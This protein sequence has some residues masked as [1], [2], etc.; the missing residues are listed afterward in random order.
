MFPSSH[1]Y[2]KWRSFLAHHET[3][4]SKTKVMKS[5][6]GCFCVMRFH[7]RVSIQVI[8][9]R[10]ACCRQLFELRSVFLAST[11]WEW[12]SP[13]KEK[14]HTRKEWNIWRLQRNATWLLRGENNTPANSGEKTQHMAQTKLNRLESDSSR[15][16]PD[17]TQTKFII[18]HFLP[19]IYRPW[20]AANMS[21][22][23]WC[24]FTVGSGT[25][26]TEPDGNAGTR[27]SLNFILRATWGSESN[28][29]AIQSTVDIK[30]LKD[31]DKE[32]KK[33]K[34]HCLIWV[35]LEWVCECVCVCVC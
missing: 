4:G 5:E 19:F 27:E 22:F 25:L 10:S 1:D 8:R 26:P 2:N 6:L 20:S 29:M 34:L 17:L 3:G 21:K 18:R 24:A 15:K 11:G 28:I 9:L 33:S 31:P 23:S 13:I 35:C 12:H 7:S 30:T 32:S 14:T 16:I